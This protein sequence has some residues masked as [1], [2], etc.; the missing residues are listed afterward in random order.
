MNFNL[1]RAFD[2]DD[3]GVGRPCSSNKSTYAVLHERVIVFG[4][5]VLANVTLLT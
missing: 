4:H 1:G 3:V 5:L 2:I